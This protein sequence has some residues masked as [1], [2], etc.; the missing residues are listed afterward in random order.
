MITSNR[1]RAPVKEATP[2]VGADERQCGVSIH[3][4]VKEATS[5][6]G[7]GSATLCFDPFQRGEVTESP[8][9]VE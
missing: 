2:V 7:S 8:K 9:L 1:L 4:P 3:A 6:T 5:A